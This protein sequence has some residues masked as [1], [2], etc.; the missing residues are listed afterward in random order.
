[1]RHENVKTTS[2]LY[3]GLSSDA[4]R[5]ASRRV[6]TFV[7]DSAAQV[8]AEREANQPLVAAAAGESRNAP[9]ICP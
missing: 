9:V 1:M 2:D 4:K 6:V 7:K 3:S 5:D 8:H